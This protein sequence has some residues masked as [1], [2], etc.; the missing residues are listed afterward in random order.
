VHPE[1]V[2]TWKF[3][4]ARPEWRDQAILTK[5]EAEALISDPRIPGDRRVLYAIL[6]L[7]GLEARAS[8]T[9]SASAPG[10]SREMIE[11]Y[12]TLDDLPAALLP[13]AALGG[14]PFWAGRDR[15]FNRL[16]RLFSSMMQHSAP[17][18]ARR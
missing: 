6:I 10:A 1:E 15:W 16:N 17:R 18:A 5:A 3:K 2:A 4:D 9:C 11:Q 14:G 8:G 13:T 7:G 12:T